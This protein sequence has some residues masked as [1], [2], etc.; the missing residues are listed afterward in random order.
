MVTLIWEEDKKLIPGS[1]RNA[2]W[3]AKVAQL[4]EGEIPERHRFDITIIFV[5][6]DRIAELNQRYRGM[7]KKTDILSFYYDPEEDTG[8]GE[9]ELYISVATMLRQ[10][11]RYRTSVEKEMARLVVHGTLHLFGYDHM[12]TKER[13]VM[14]GFEKKIMAMA[15]KNLLI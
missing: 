7:A 14:R 5:S 11:R 15:K 8:R 9:G 1:L 4:V 10:A 6:D 13:V 12:K 2:R 3:Y